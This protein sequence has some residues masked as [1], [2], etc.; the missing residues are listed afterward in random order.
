L[1]RAAGR[2]RVQGLADE[3]G[4]L[5][6]IFMVN[7]R[8]MFEFVVTEASLREVVNR[9]RPGDTQWVYDVLDTLLIQSDGEESPTP[10]QAFEDPR[11]GMIS[12]NDRRLLQEALGWRRLS[13]RS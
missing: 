9:I 3:I 4:A 8:A 12:V 10:G 5:Q 11:F 7:Q 6:M 2:P 13:R 1:N